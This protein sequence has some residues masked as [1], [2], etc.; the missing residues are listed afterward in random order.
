MHREVIAVV[1]DNAD[2]RLLLQA[3]LEDRY[4][5][6]EYGNGLDAMLGFSSLLPDLVLLDISLPEMDGPDVLRAIRADDRLRRLPVVALTAH[7]MTGDRERFLQLGF[8]SYV[9]KPIIDEQE[10]LQTIETLLRRG[11]DAGERGIEAGEQTLGR[12]GLLYEDRR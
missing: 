9:A 4:T 7:A 6:V 12:E 3:L 2:N 11:D 1:E 10:L 8:D 5:L